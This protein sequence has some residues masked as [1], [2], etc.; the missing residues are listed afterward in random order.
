MTRVIL[1]LASGRRILDI[2]MKYYK[3]RLVRDFSDS[4]A[5]VCHVKYARKYKNLYKK[6]KS[7][8]VFSL[9][10]IPSKTNCTVCRIVNSSIVPQARACS[11]PSLKLSLI[12]G[13]QNLFLP[14]ASARTLVHWTPPWCPASALLTPLWTVWSRYAAGTRGSRVTR[15]RATWTRL[16]SQC[17]PSPPCLTAYCTD[18]G[19]QETS[20]GTRRCRQC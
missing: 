16:F 3:A 18:P 13:S 6:R 7:C 20:P 12:P 4:L 5:T 14:R 2:M 19:G 11:S 15:T 17:S 9:P 1:A 10:F 8:F